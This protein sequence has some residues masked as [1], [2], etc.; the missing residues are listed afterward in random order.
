MK[1]IKYL[2][3]FTFFTILIL[4]SINKLGESHTDIVLDYIYD[5]VVD[6]THTYLNKIG[7]SESSGRYSVVNEHGY[8]GKYQFSPNTLRGL[9]ILVNKKQFLNNPSLQ[10][11]AMVV[12]LI[13]N[14]KILKRYIDE[15]SG[16]EINGNTITESGILA[17]AHLVGP[18]RTKLLLK[19]GIDYS[20]AYG[21][22]A[23][24]YLTKFSGYNLNL[25]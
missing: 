6:D 19:N 22:K 9:D 2:V 11:S 3:L 21:T 1:K 25:N 20:D 23:S 7:Y 8:M 12:L 4:I 17:S 18:Y 10:D 15:Y 5:E 14:R 24:E 13:H 16:I